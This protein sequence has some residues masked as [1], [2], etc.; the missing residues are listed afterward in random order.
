[1]AARSRLRWR[2]D[3]AG[4]LADAGA[5]ILSVLER[6]YVYG[7][8]RAH[9]LPRADRQ[10][11]SRVGCR[12]R[13]LD[14]LYPQFGV[15]VE[16]D[17]R[18]AHPAESRWRDIHRDNASATAGIITLRYGW[19]DVTGRACRVA[20]ETAMVLQRRGWHGRPRPCGAGCLAGIIGEDSQSL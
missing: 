10:S 9:G 3:L 5:G 7:V 16:V 11:R 17:G 4:V 6:R 1:M 8:E 2:S 20:A 19:A 18:A 15:A 14:N 12:T 13:Y